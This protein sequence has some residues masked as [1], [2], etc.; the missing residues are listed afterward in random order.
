MAISLRNVTKRFR[1]HLTR[2]LTPA[3]TDVSFDVEPGE[4]FGFLGPNGAG[5]STTIKILLNLI[6]PTSGEATVLGRPVAETTIRREIGYLPESPYFYDYLTP[7]EL[8]WFGGRA[9]GLSSHTIKTRAADLLS[10]VDL[11][12]VMNR[13]LRGFSKGML[14]RVGLALALVNDPRLVILDEP[15]S[16]LDPLG[17]RMVADLIKRLKAEGKTVFFSSHILPDVEGLCDRIGII[18]G[19]RLRTVL[20]LQD[21]RLSAPDGWKIRVKAPPAMLDD[22]ISK[23][24]ALLKQ[25]LHWVEISVKDAALCELLVKI[26]EAGG[27]I[28]SVD[29]ERETLEDIFLRE[30]GAVKSE[31]V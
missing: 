26:R 10:I 9:S 20:S 21:H 13:P 27:V 16:G 25:E 15:M 19:G 29:P 11:G 24:G 28:I 2:R 3:L 5:K 31:V 6:F 12:S 8:L 14:Q 4:V 7:K 23:S 17:R 22:Y 1:E 18:V 30:V